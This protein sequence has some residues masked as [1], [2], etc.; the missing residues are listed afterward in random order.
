MGGLDTDEYE[1]VLKVLFPLLFIVSLF[2]AAL[3]L[4][5]K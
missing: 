5:S 1:P 3:V 4:V 2:I